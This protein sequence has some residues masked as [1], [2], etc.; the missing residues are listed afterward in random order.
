M[1]DVGFV[2]I[3]MLI[4]S[5]VVSVSFVFFFCFWGGRLVVVV[6]TGDVEVQR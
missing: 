4:G 3:M 2:L 5:S 1:Y 6:I